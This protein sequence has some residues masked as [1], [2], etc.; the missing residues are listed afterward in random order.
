MV[1]KQYLC[2]GDGIVRILV[3]IHLRPGSILLTTGDETCKFP[4]LF[5]LLIPR[6]PFPFTLPSYTPHS[7]LPP[8]APPPPPELVMSSE[9]YQ[10][11]QLPD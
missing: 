5:A 4:F 7:V 3:C 8:T 11:K 2:L 10:F 6:P 9:L 1:A